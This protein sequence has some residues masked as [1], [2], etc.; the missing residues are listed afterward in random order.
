M[1]MSGIYKENAGLAAKI[2][3]DKE[4]EA[5]QKELKERY[6]INDENV[7]VVEKPSLAKFLI[8]LGIRAVNLAAT[9]IILCLGVIGLLGLI[10]PEPR[11]ALY[12]LYLEII[13]QVTGMI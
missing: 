2:R 5:K 6:K 8:K 9:I 11:E 7:V 10:Y 12:D 13:A 3:V 1:N 4:I